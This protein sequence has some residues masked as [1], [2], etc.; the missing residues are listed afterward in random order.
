VKR[1]VWHGVNRW[2]VGSELRV[3]E[4]RRDDLSVRDTHGERLR[5]FR[6]RQQRSVKVSDR[7]KSSQN[8][9]P[10]RSQSCLKWL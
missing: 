10:N 9:K 7:V 8:A 4:S 2:H 1:K 3:S 5:G 6:H